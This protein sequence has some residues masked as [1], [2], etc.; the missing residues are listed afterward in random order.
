[1]QEVET[2]EQANRGHSILQRFR[3]PWR[4]FREPEDETAMGRMLDEPN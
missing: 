2:K 3:M 4:R 1:M